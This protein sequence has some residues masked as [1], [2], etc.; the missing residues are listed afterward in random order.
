MIFF[1]EEH[2][3]QTLAGF[4]K[5]FLIHDFAVLLDL[6]EGKKKKEIDQKKMHEFA[7][8]LDLN[9]TVLVIIILLYYYYYYNLLSSTV[10][11]VSA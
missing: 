2:T 11:S 9:E 5:P 3:A 4:V 7:V 6:K 1:F 10:V 8:V